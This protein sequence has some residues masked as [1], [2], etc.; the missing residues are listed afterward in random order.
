VRVFTSRTAPH[1][2]V[3][4]WEMRAPAPLSAGNFLPEE[5]SSLVFPKSSSSIIKPHVGLCGFVLSLQKP[6]AL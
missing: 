1:L 6:V 5:T 4:P 2:I 3:R